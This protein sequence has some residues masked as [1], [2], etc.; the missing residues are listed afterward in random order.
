[1]YGEYGENMSNL[2]IYGNYGEAVQEENL[3]NLLLQP[4]DGSKSN[5]ADK[6]SDSSTKPQ[7]WEGLKD[8][9]LD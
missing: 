7:Y 5:D 2:Q 8:E 9:A 1:M 3:V 4:Q 6:N